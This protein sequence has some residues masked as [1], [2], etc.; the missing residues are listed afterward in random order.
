MAKSEGVEKYSSVEKKICKPCCSLGMFKSAWAGERNSELFHIPPPC[1]DSTKMT[2]RLRVGK[3]GFLF[4][5][6]QTFLRPARYKVSYELCQH[7]KKKSPSTTPPLYSI[8]QVLLVSIVSFGFCS[9]ADKVVTSSTVALERG[10]LH[11]IVVT[12]A[13]YFCLYVFYS[14]QIQSTA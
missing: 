12:L 10:L 1:L 5:G 3:D 4:A 2:F 8:T 11:L 13:D 6:W 7:P 9:P 14:Q